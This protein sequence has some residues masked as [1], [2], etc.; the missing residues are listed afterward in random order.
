MK[1]SFSVKKIVIAAA[2]VV[3]IAAA[4]AAAVKLPVY[5][6]LKTPFN[7]VI[8][9]YK[10]ADSREIVE[11]L[12]DGLI[13]K[14]DLSEDDYDDMDEMLQESS[15]DV[16]A[17]FLNDDDY[18]VKVKILGYKKIN[19]K[20]LESMNDMY[21][22]LEA[23]VNIK[24]AYYVDF[25]LSVKSPED[26]LS[27][28]YGVTVGKADGEWCLVGADML[29]NSVLIPS[30]VEY[31]DKAELKTANSNAKTAYNAVAEY[32]ADQETMGIPMSESIAKLSGETDC[33]SGAPDNEARMAIYDALSANGP[34]YAGIVNVFMIEDGYETSFVV[35]WRSDESSPVIGQYPD[36]VS[37]DDCND[38][39]V[40]W[41]TYNEGYDYYEY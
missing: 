4:A 34:S 37:W 39:N 21:S 40:A 23:D 10:D 18:N 26:D 19:K 31:A 38:G 20:Q 22:S 32:V 7:H 11:A 28:T 35:Q 41:G 2:A 13:E 1:K 8:R 24:K 30:A 29:T 9:G 25:K 3:V 12:P 27:L 36:P 16:L 33:R 15:D 14:L 5:I 17:E 6:H